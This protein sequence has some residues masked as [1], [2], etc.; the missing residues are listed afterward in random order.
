MIDRIIIYNYRSLGEDVGTFL[1]PLTALVGPNASGK[2]NFLDALRFLAESVTGSLSHAV[3]VRHGYR[4]ICRWG[5]GD[6]SILRFGVAVSE[7][8]GDGFWMFSLESTPEEEGFK[9]RREQAV[10]SPTGSRGQNLRLLLEALMLE[11]ADE[12]E[13]WGIS[14]TKRKGPFGFMRGNGSLKA[15]PSFGPLPGVKDTTLLLPL[16]GETPLAPLLDDLRG[17][18]IYST[19][20]APQNPSPIKPMTSVGDNWASTLMEIDRSTGGLDLIDAL[21]RITGDIDDYRVTQAGGFL[22]PEFRHGVAG[23]EGRE[24]WLGAAQ[25]SDGTLRVAAILTALFQEPPPSFIGFE[26]PELWVH[27]GAMPI[28]FGFLNEASRRSNILFTTHSPDLIDCV[29]DHQIRVALRHAGSSR[30]ALADKGRRDL[31]R[32][33]LMP[34]AISS[35]SKGRE[36]EE[37]PKPARRAAKDA[38]SGRSKKVAK[39]K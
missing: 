11:P 24:R 38:T 26:E 27:P 39:H 5:I 17:I 29:L 14:S 7:A 16:L 23:P 6:P 19:L 25:E 15:A 4:S 1:G 12:E 3:A 9:I 2:S 36:R 10:W 30:V 37:A 33:R 28:L 31:G 20:R 22:I 35:S 21:G 34:T 18:A 8:Q 13:G 32:K